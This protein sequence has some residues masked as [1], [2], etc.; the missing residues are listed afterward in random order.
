MSG[1]SERLVIVGGGPLEGELKALAKE[2][3][4]AQRVTFTDTL[5]NP[6]PWMKHAKLFVL[7]SRVEGLGIVLVESLACGTP[8]V[9]VDCPGGIRDVLVDEQRD[10]LAEANPVSLA[11]KIHEGLKHPPKINES[12]ISRFEATAVV[13]QFLILQ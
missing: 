9:S 1:I 8:V 2:L 10:Y 12:W 7:S 3:G 6:Y 13:D 5:M 4:V 11:D